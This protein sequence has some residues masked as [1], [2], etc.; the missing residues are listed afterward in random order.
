MLSCVVV[1]M[2]QAGPSRE[3]PV[4]E[5]VHAAEPQD[6]KN[7][8][9]AMGT[10]AEGPRTYGPF[11]EAWPASDTA[12]RGSMG[13]K[14]VPPLA[15]AGGWFCVIEGTHCKISLLASVDIAVGM[16]LPAS[17]KGPDMPYAQ[18]GVRGG[19]VL[20]P[21]ALVGASWHPWGI[22]LASSWSR[23]NGSVTMAGDATGGRVASTS[24]T[25]S[26]RIALVNQLWLGQKPHRSW[27]G[28]FSIGAVRSEVLTTHLKRWGTHAEVAF[29][30]GGWA[31]LFASG[32][33][34]DEDA[35]VMLGLRVH[36]LFGGPVAGVAAA[37]LAAGGAL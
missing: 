8:N 34:L 15:I 30:L 36:A 26:V 33:F 27:H 22:G 35:R 24:H 23:G 37:G 7:D 12:H 17:D 19:F 2:L 11:F 20:R 13:S 10:T 28:D 31:A 1:V 4:P 29:G 25:D 9:E 14:S 6:P 21:K 18:F 3:P 5:R 16:R 32:D